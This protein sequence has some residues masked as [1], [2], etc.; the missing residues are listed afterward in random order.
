MQIRTGIAQMLNMNF[1][2]PP[3]Q[4]TMTTKAMHEMDNRTSRHVAHRKKEKPG[5]KQ[6][7]H[8]MHMNRQK[9]HMQN[10]GSAHRLGDARAASGN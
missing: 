6:S 10:R 1:T 4:G 3:T 7:K 8:D 2:V 5:W 9:C